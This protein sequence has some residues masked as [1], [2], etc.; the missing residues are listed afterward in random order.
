[1]LSRGGGAGY[2]GVGIVC[3]CAHCFGVWWG[4]HNKTYES[5]C[6][7]K[8]LVLI[9]TRSWRAHAKHAVGSRR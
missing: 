6:P 9:T 3:V 1:M 8:S 5:Y 7:S 4:G 2:G